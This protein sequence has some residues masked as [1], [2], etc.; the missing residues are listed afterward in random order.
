MI[1][2]PCPCFVYARFAATYVVRCSA[3]ALLLPAALPLVSGSGSEF[4]VHVPGSPLSH[5]VLSS[6]SLL[7]CML[8]AIGGWCRASCTSCGRVQVRTRFAIIAALASTIFGHP[9]AFNICS[10]LIVKKP[11][12]VH[13]PVFRLALRSC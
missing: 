7:Q 8:S 1:L 4:R 12:F 2:A 10:S 13:R 11:E 5:S 6:L 9:S 3:A